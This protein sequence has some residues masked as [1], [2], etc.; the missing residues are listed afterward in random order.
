M[1]ADEY[2]FENLEVAGGASAGF[3]LP[4]PHRG[5]IYRL[6]VVQ[7]DGALQGFTYTLYNDPQACPAGPF[8]TPAPA[9][10][11]LFAVAGPCEVATSKAYLAAGDVW[12]R[13]GAQGLYVPYM[14]RDGLGVFGS[15]K[16]ALR[17]RIDAAGTGDKQF[18]AALT[19]SQGEYA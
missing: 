13:G 12:V 18:G 2:L 11:Q 15:R 9:R 8:A 10:A 17:L 14:T 4:V 5:L 6:A 1:P 7:T 19:L 3:D 16:Y